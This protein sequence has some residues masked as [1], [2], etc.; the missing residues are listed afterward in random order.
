MQVIPMVML[1][2]GLKGLNFAGGVVAQSKS[3]RGSI[4]DM[5]SGVWLFRFVVC[6]SVEEA[7]QTF[8]DGVLAALRRRVN[9]L[10]MEKATNASG[11]STKNRTAISNR[12]WR[13]QS[14]LS[15]R[16]IIT[17]NGLGK[18]VPADD[19]LRAF[20]PPSS[21]ISSV[22]VGDAWSLDDGTH[23]Q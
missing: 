20:I 8:M 7:L 5:G 13:H 3:A 2:T 19:A 10:A 4:G 1:Y 23:S 12:M 17:A 16:I 21:M 11:S 9:A 15:L 6:F 22:S 18:N 14:V